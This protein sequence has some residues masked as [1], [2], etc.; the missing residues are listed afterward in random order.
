LPLALA[1][2]KFDHEKAVQDRKKAADQLVKLKKDRQL[3]V[4]KAPIGGI[5]YYGGATRGKWGDK[6]KINA[7]LRPGGTIA[8]K[9]V[10]MTIVAQQPLLVRVNLEEKNLHRVRRGMAGV[11]IPTGFPGRRQPVSVVRVSQVPIAAGVF[12]CLLE[13]KPSDRPSPVRPGMT[14]NVKFPTKG[15]QGKAKGKAKK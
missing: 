15:K 2:K 7:Q 8:P 6:A 5:V 1:K 14:C 12:D 11:A 10:V 3:A 4:I 9:Q 13:V